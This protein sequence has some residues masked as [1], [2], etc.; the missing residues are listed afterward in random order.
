M[1][2]EIKPI[3][4]VVAGRTEVADDYWGGIESVIQLDENEF[5]LDS[6]QGL[7]EFSHLV[8]VWH[9]NQA[10][11]SDVEYHARSPRGNP[12]WPATGTFAHR[13]HRRPNQLAQSFPKLLK[14]EGL[15]LHVSD[16]DAV[17]GTKIYDLSP[18][19]QEMGPRDAIRE[20]KWPGEM[21]A[22][23]WITKE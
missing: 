20:P 3:G 19:F 17:V 4:E 14:V 13:N 6:V 7:E 21:L 12:D 1:T 10:A 18:Y 2:L 8:V 5:P 23:Y 22:D 16:L 9:F 15:R 11:P